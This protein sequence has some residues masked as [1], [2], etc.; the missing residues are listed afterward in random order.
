[1][2]DRH[3]LGNGTAFFPL[4][5]QRE[6]PAARLSIVSARYSKE[7]TTSVCVVPRA[8]LDAKRERPPS[9]YGP[10]RSRK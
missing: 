6:V 7:Y 4:W 2:T 3:T 1:M 9:H 10:F 5:R 8:V